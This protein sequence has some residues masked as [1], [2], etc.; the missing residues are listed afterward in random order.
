MQSSFSYYGFSDG[1]PTHLLNCC[2]STAAELPWETSALWGLGQGA[3]SLRSRSETADTVHIHSAV[4]TLSD[5]AHGSLKWQNDQAYQQRIVIFLER[6]G[7]RKDAI[8]ELRPQMKPHLLWV[9]V[10]FVP[11][12]RNYHLPREEVSFRTQSNWLPDCMAVELSVTELLILGLFL[13][14]IICS[15]NIV[16][17]ITCVCLLLHF[18]VKAELAPQQPAETLKS[19]RPFVLTVAYRMWRH[20]LPST[21]FSLNLQQKPSDQARKML[22]HKVT[23]I[24]KYIFSSKDWLRQKICDYRN[25]MRQIRNISL[26][27]CKVG[28]GIY[29][30]F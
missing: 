8:A 29:S 11:F 5:H 13:E 16:I 25:V 28:W 23:V 12:H 10:K 20:D 2:H 27:A 15:F 21:A 9:T 3:V 18:V 7:K 19:V 14:N 1:V 22:M 30:T 17:L 6:M 24:T 4:T 26:C